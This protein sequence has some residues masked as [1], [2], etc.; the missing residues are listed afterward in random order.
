MPKNN[1]VNGGYC[2]W[3]ASLHSR[4]YRVRNSVLAAA[5][6][7]LARYGPRNT[8]PTVVLK[9]ELAQSYIAQPKISRLS[10]GWMEGA[11]VVMKVSPGRGYWI[12]I[13][14]NLKIK[15]SGG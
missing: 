9:A 4:P 7:R 1:A 8:V 13:S 12:T 5:S 15:T 11:G 10:F 2:A 3:I 14:G 6:A